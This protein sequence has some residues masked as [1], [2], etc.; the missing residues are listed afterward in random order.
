MAM[1]IKGQPNRQLGRSGSTCGGR[2]WTSTC[3]LR[4]GGRTPCPPKAR[5]E[6][7]AHRRATVID[8]AR[9]GGAAIVQPPNGGDS[10]NCFRRVGET[11]KVR[12]GKEEGT[13]ETWRGSATC[14]G[15]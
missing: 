14:R 10:P 7:A 15:C 8:D 12:F 9:G 3:R 1:P 5:I 13:F 4:A 2:R 6:S 11:W